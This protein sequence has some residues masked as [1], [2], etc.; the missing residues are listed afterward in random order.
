MPSKYSNNS[1]RCLTKSHAIHDSIFEADVCNRLLA[2]GIPY[3]TQY[4]I[5]LRIRGIL[6]CRHR[7]DFAEFKTWAA[8]KLRRNPIKFI[9]AKGYDTPEWKL[10]KKLTEAIFTKIPYEVLRRAK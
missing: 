4:V 10:K 8:A 6:I 7:V 5:E 1:C 9:E 2:G 3:C